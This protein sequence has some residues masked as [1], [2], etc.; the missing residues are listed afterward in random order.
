[1]IEQ[2]WIYQTERQLPFSPTAGQ[3]DAVAVF[4][5]FM[6]DR[7]PRAA[8]ILRGS[9]GTGKT[10]VARAIVM[11][12]TV[13]G[14]KVVL[15]APT[16]RA[17]K[18]FEQGIASSSIHAYTVHRK[19]YRQMA[20]MSDSFVLADNMHTDTL[21]M[22]D[23][24]SMVSTSGFGSGGMFGGGNLLDDLIRY[25]YSGRNCRLV[26]IGDTAQLPPIGS[27][28]APALNS[29][30]IAGY[31]LEVYDNDMTEVLRQSQE[32]GILWNATMLR[33]LITHDDITMLPRIRFD[34][35]ADI[36][37]CP[38]NE[39]TD[40]LGASY[41]RVGMEE[42][43]VVTRSNKRANVYNIGIRNLVLDREEEL[44]SG[45][46][47]MIVKNNYYW[48]ETLKGGSGKEEEG[49]EN[50]PAFL[51]N[52]DSCVVR[53]IRN[54]RSLYGFRFADVLL[55]FPDYDG[56]EMETTVILDTL[57]S[58][59]P[60]LT[61]EQQNALYSGVLE[62]YADIPGKQERLKSLKQDRLFNALQ[63]KYAYAVTCHKAQGGQWAHVY[64]DQGYMTDDMLTPSY[65]H[66]LYTA[67]TRATEHLYLVNW[68]KE[69]TESRQ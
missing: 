28:E 39:L 41:S 27:E 49:R 26:L 19:I 61:G 15:L 2:E 69:Q 57:H 58:E 20:Y 48:T 65:I 22:V 52:G 68:R 7:R 31:G 13:M 46:L 47:L 16:G 43:I 66:W 21:F 50:L 12:M 35:F 33:S 25:V 40:S 56:L 5:R 44:S 55:E 29:D 51:A 60:A 14:Q 42:T 24:A 17:A 3:H 6:T 8:M 10:S 64:I 62:D 32:S 45:D 38:G 9:A 54:S 63:I 23:E 30:Y 1:M 59:A 53:R 36:T 11:A 4:S 37:V 18:V 67:F 34:G